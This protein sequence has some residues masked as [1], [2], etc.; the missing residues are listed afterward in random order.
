MSS[1]RMD[2]LIFC[3][4]KKQPPPPHSLMVRQG[5]IKHDVCKNSCIYEK[6][7]EKVIYTYLVYYILPG[8]ILRGDS[9]RRS[10]ARLGSAHSRNC[11]GCSIDR[12][13]ETANATVLSK[14]TYTH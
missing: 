12:L 13:I 6:K 7:L 4:A 14:V 5:H 2:Y 9:P 8:T 1:I 11:K 3:P 10:D